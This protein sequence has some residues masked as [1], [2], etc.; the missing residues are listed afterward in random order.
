M[1]NVSLSP[2]LQAWNELNHLSAEELSHQSLDKRISLFTQSAQYLAE[3]RTVLNIDLA[4]KLIHHLPHQCIDNS[5]IQ[6]IL[7]FL[8]ESSVLNQKNSSDHEKIMHLIDEVITEGNE[9]VAIALIESGCPIGKEVLKN[10]IMKSMPK[11]VCL[12][13]EKKLF[14]INQTD[15]EGNTLLKLAVMSGNTEVVKMLIEANININA[16]DKTDWSALNWAADHQDIELIEILTSKSP[17]SI[18][19]W[20]MKN[21][22]DLTLFNKILV[23]ESNRKKIDQLDRVGYD[24]TPLIYATMEERPE[25]KLLIQ[26]GADINAADGDGGTALILAVGKGNLENVKILLKAGKKNKYF[27][28]NH[29][30]KKGISALMNAARLRSPEIMQLLLKAGAKVNVVDNMGNTVL[31]YA[32]MSDYLK[33]VEILLEAGKEDDK[34]NINHEDEDGRSA[35]IIAASNNRQKIM[36][37]LLEEGAVD[38]DGNTA[39]ILAVE[40]DN[41]EN[42]K[43]LLEAGKKNKH[44]NINHVNKDGRSALITAAMYDRPEIM[45]LLLKAGADINAVDR[46][47]NTALIYATIKDYPK[48]V[49]ILL[50][51]GKEDGKLNI[52]QLNKKGFSALT[53]AAHKCRQKILRLLLSAGANPVGVFSHDINI[54]SKL[55]N[56][57]LLKI[58]KVLPSKSLKDLAKSFGYYAHLQETMR[59]NALGH[60]F[61]LEGTYQ[62]T[63]LPRLTSAN[64]ELITAASSPI[65]L[66]NMSKASQL[67]KDKFPDLLPGEEGKLLC[68]TLSY[69]ADFHHRSK[70]QLLK[71]IKSGKPVILPVGYSGHTV[72]ALIWGSCAK[73]E[74]SEGVENFDSLFILCNRGAS[75]R[76]PVEVYRFDP[77]Q[78]DIELLTKM[79]NI[80]EQSDYQQLFFDQLPK[81]LA[82][83]SGDFEKALEGSC[84]LP[85]QRV[86]NCSWESPETAVWAFC[87]LYEIIVKAGFQG[88]NREFLERSATAQ[89]R[90]ENWLF[91]NQLYQL[92]RYVN[93]RQLRPASKPDKLDA[94][95][96]QVYQIQPKLVEQ[97]LQEIALT[98]AI[99]PK[100]KQTFVSL[101]QKIQDQHLTIQ[102]QHLTIDI[103]PVTFLF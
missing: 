64:I 83:K 87:Q 47:G 91:F 9:S 28:I 49:K 72:Q 54:D 60:S 1:Q 56:F 27:N 33:N 92:E 58:D 42:V 93:I 102:D 71:R 35:Y 7:T 11:V 55:S 46:G 34:F 32:I 53:Y 94:K 63:V 4:T 36:Q 67:M 100:L 78:L 80:Q 62:M 20:A 81:Q 6:K 43:K 98:P 66:R 68:Q 51:A 57:Y 85:N 73:I 21:N 97:V 59:L 82:F 84:K 3:N 10:A 16:V 19:I 31:T 13:I 45:Q 88:I 5:N 52:N 18:L 26:A 41:L 90:F 15:N 61:K 29:V 12:L 39:L 30:N 103:D 48:S 101:K 37:L 74:N 65:W 40:N 86:G 69:A 24:L 95:Q 77:S 75:S 70:E 89:T 23:M 17:K 38:R 79:T 99:D 50:E 44:F 76:R 2:L 8:K 22:L 25:F 96:H 14:D